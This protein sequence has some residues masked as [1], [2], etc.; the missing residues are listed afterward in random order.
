MCRVIE[1]A[2]LALEHDPEKACPGLDPGWE[3]VFGKDHAPMENLDHDPIP[4]DRSWFNRQT[5]K[6]PISGRV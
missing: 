1:A 3:P 4:S 6:R 2:W 5:Q